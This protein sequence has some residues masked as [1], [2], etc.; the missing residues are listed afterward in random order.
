MLIN[1]SILE[2]QPFL[3]EMHARQ[4]ELLAEN[5]MP[6]EFQAGDFI[7]KEGGSAN[8]FYI[9]LEGL[10]ELES[11]GYGGEAVRIQRLGAGDALGWSWLFPPYYL[12]FDA[13]AVTPT[14]TLFFYG[15]R[16]RELCEENHDLGY[17][18]MTRFTEIIIKR[19]QAARRE[20]VEHKQMLSEMSGIAAQ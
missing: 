9:I 10:V 20:L 7:L 17:Q 11:R 4:L 3:R 19:L 5:C 13:R 8:R 6:A 15:T 2:A 1:K 12:H 16:L 18:L 14:K